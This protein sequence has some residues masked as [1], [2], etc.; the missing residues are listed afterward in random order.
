MWD[1]SVPPS[2]D[3]AVAADAPEGNRDDAENAAEPHP[4]PDPNPN[5]LPEALTSLRM[6]LPSLVITMPPM[7][8]RSICNPKRSTAGNGSLTRSTHSLCRTG[9]AAALTFI[10]ALGPR[11]VRMMSA[12][13]CGGQRELGD[14]RGGRGAHA[15][16]QGPTR[17]TS[18]RPALHLQHCPDPQRSE[19]AA[20]RRA[21]P[22]PPRPPPPRRGKASMGSTPPQSVT[23]HP[24]P[25]PSC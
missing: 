14:T 8:S 23:S 6:A 25:L 7:G 24:H 20:L 9:T 17:R 12:M 3:P 13:V 2:G 1:H 22:P 5:P 11:H 4:N 15:A 21:S 18:P 16:L 10:I 19:G